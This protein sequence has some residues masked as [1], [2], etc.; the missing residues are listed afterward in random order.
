MNQMEKIGSTDRVRIV[1]Q[2]DRSDGYNSSNGNWTGCRRYY[3]RKDTIDTEIS[4]SGT[5]NS[6]MLED[7]GEVDMGNPNVL[8]D[9]IRWG[10][11]KY[12]ADHYCLVIWNHGSGWRSAVSNAIKTIPRNVSFDDTSGT[13]I[14]TIDMPNALAGSPEPIDLIA[15]DASLMQMLEIAYELKDSAP[16]VVASEES[17][18]GDGYPYDQWLGKLVTSPG[19]SARQLGQTIVDEYINHYSE[20]GHEYPSTESL[21]D[22]ANIENVAQSA[23]DLAAAILPHVNSDEAALVTARQNS[24][25]YAFEYYKDLIDYAGM[26]HQLI[27][28]PAITTAYN[29]L[30]VALNSAVI[31]ERHTGSEVSRS[32]GLSIYMPEDPTDYVDSYENLSF[33]QDYPNWAELIKA[34]R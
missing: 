27:P 29:N 3:I 24:Q 7:M 14:R 23:D 33:T 34:Q 12:P 18:H 32:H 13:S 15:M 6:T 2:M 25:A 8:R 19:M 4:V 9:F 26:V 11:Q 30:Q 10:Q 1:V 28:D 22:L 31:F 16:L 21:I 5:L 17:P 20:P